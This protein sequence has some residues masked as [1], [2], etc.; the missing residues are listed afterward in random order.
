[1]LNQT[2]VACQFCLCLMAWL[3][4]SHCDAVVANAQDTPGPHCSLLDLPEFKVQGAQTQLRQQDDGSLSIRGRGGLSWPGLHLLADEPGVDIFAYD[5]LRATVTNTGQATIGIWAHVQS[6]PEHYI[7]TPRYVAPGSTRTIQLKLTRKDPYWERINL[8]GIRTTP[9]MDRLKE[10]ADLRAVTTIG[11]YVEQSRQDFSFTVQDISLAGSYQ[12]PDYPENWF[13]F[14]DRFGQLRHRTWDEKIL[15]DRDLIASRDQ[16]ELQPLA[17]TNRF[18]GFPG[19]HR[20]Q[21]SGHFAIQKNSRGDWVLTDPAGAYFFSFGINSANFNNPSPIEGRED[22]FEWLPDE[23]GEFGKYRSPAPEP[24]RFGHYKGFRPLCVDFLQINYHRK[25][26]PD[27]DQ[28]IRKRTLQRLRAW[29]INTIG[30]WSDETLTAQGHPYTLI[31]Y[32][33][34]KQIRSSAGIYGY[35]PDPFSAT[36]AQG[37]R[38]TLQQLGPQHLDNPDCLGIF[39]H[40][41]LGWGDNLL[42]ALQTLRGQ[43]DQDAKRAFVEMLKNRYNHIDALNAAWGSELASWDVLLEKPFWADPQRA[44]KDLRAFGKLLAET[45]FKTC[46]DLIH[47]LAPGRL[48]LGCRFA[49]NNEI[50]SAAAVRFC[51]VV[52]VNLYFFPDQIRG[53]ALPGQSPDAAPLM[54]SEF[55]YGARDRAFARGLRGGETQAERAEMLGQA[56]EAIAK[57]PSFVGAHW[58]QLYDQPLTGRASDGEN[59]QIGFLDNTDSP[60]TAVVES[61]K[62]NLIQIYKAKTRAAR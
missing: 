46:R 38:Q 53:Y 33:P 9:W 49:Q 30:A 47:E 34:C 18:G 11:L 31:L 26:G 59:Y 5:T 55:H 10:P 14:V 12:K 15:N 21:A 23:S 52:S 24:A 19:E 44:Q 6:K 29:G 4:A 16:E 56:L 51:D 7:S 17:G 61:L 8:F 13:P 40:N 41:E 22:W 57:H 20:W 58:F 25:Y 2:A 35:F 39:V 27:W 1:M 54:L 62:R 32:P 3:V 45:Y 50:A 37:L 28:T 48:Y 36:L 43:G 42:L 60:Y